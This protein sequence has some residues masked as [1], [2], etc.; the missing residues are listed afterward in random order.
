MKTIMSILF[1]IILFVSCETEYINTTE[2]T[3]E[4]RAEIELET[5][6]KNRIVGNPYTK[7]WF[8]SDFYSYLM[9]YNYVY[10]NGF[11]HG[12]NYYDDIIGKWE[13]LREILEFYNNDDFYYCE[14]KNNKIIEIK[15]K[16]FITDSSELRGE[17]I[18]KVIIYTPIKWIDEDT[19]YLGLPDKGVY[20]TRII[21][22]KKR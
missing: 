22:E 10:N 13:S 12:F 14:N 19:I 20:F 8:N 16:Y 1:S 15:G 18:Y 11:K 21:E 9:D 7:T 2:T 5:G 3:A 4:T 6:T 17:S